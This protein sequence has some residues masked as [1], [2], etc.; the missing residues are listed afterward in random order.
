ML[1]RRLL[2]L[3]AVM[4]GLTALAAGMAPRR[5]G[6]ALGPAAPMPQEPAAA[7]A[8]TP[9]RLRVVPRDE[10][11]AAFAPRARDGVRGSALGGDH[12]AGAA[13]GR[14]ALWIVDVG[15]P[16]AHGRAT[17]AHEVS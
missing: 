10:A 9:R 16:G 3:L 8:R 17:L 12:G 2:V 7:P 6:P 15:R 13:A 5:T 4:V 1:A 14:A 11:P